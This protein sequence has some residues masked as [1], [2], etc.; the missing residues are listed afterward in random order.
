[1]ANRSAIVIES[2][3]PVV[4]DPAALIPGAAKPE[5][6]TYSVVNVGAIPGAVPDTRKI[7]TTAPLTGGGD[8]SA[9]RTLAIPAATAVADGYMTSTQA[10]L[11]NGATASDIAS[12]LML[13]DASQTTAIGALQIDTAPAAPITGGV[14]KLVWNDTDGTLEFQLK[15]GNVTLQIG[16]EQVTRV[17]NKTGADIGDGVV[18]YLSGAQ[19][20]RPKVALA[21]ANAEA[22]SQTTI[23][24]T[25]EA[26]A[27]NAEGFV[28]IAG[29]VHKIDMGTAAEGDVLYLSPTTAGAFTNVEPSAPNHAV[30]LGLCVVAGPQGT[31]LVAV[32]NGYEL[33]ELHDVALGVLASGDLLRYN[34]TTWSNYPAATLLAAYVLKA[35]DT[36]TGTLGMTGASTYL[37]VGTAT[38]SAPLDIRNVVSYRNTNVSQLQVALAPGLLQENGALGAADATILTTYLGKFSIYKRNAVGNFAAG[39]LS[40]SVDSVGDVTVERGDET[41]GLV[42]LARIGKI[43]VGTTSPQVPVDA[44]GTSTYRNTG[45]TQLQVGTAPALMQENG[46]LGAND[47]FVISTYNG[48]ALFYKGNRAG[49]LAASDLKVTIDSDGRMQIGGSAGLNY[50]TATTALLQLAAGTA[51]AGTA[52][53]KFTSGTSLT[54]IESGAVEFDGT[55]FYGS[56]TFRSAFVR[57][58]HVSASLT[59]TAVA[60][61]SASVQTYTVSGLVVPHAVTVS[62]PSINSGLGIMWARCSATDTLEI[63]WRNFTGGALTPASGTYRVAGVRV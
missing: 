59:P 24:I 41:V 22:T 8:L 17:V 12:T 19:G 46:A 52:P 3:T 27:K 23:G 26:I 32:Q 42:K 4:L 43:G 9:D 28:T 61:N 50:A 1:M 39:D 57:G 6:G 31:M 30:V 37:G 54:A 53:L 38:P 13:R 34:G 44:R 33:G 58:V 49:N 16:E 48:K 45:V 55:S 5:G 35:G 25:T 51:T 63:C 21:K 18:V 10:G 20:Q 56:T 47:F 62:P 2:A 40:W 11:V 36:M 14:G 15:G 29:L 60:A 7:N